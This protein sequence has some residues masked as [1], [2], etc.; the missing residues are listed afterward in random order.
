MFSRTGLK[1]LVSAITCNTEPGGCQNR[2]T[3]IDAGRRG[4]GPEA[5]GGGGGHEHVKPPFISLL[6][7]MK[8]ALNGALKAEG[9][10]L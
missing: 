3:K 8:A 7:I 1:R 2:G 6:K 10:A 9:S 4:D 5:G